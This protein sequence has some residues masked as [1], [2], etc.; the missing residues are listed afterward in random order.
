MSTPFSTRWWTLQRDGM[1]VWVLAG[2]GSDGGACSVG[3]FYFVMHEPMF[4][5]RLNA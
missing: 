4:N 2:V 5:S 1:V 3:N